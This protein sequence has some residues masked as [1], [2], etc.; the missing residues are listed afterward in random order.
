MYTLLSLKVTSINCNLV[1]CINHYCFLNR[2][3]HQGALKF[4]DC[5][6]INLCKYIVILRNNV[7][8]FN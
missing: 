7:W 8:A 1:V 3:S 5:K 6:I 4:M 2:H